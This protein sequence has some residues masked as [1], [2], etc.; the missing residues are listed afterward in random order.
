MS[1]VLLSAL[2]LGCV[3]YALSGGK[4]PVGGGDSGVEATD[5]LDGPTAAIAAEPLV[6]IQAVCSAPTREVLVLESTGEA[7]LVVNSLTLADVTTGELALTLPSP[8]PFSIPAGTTA[9]VVITWTPDD[10]DY[11][12]TLD[13]ALVIASTAHA[14]PTVRVAVAAENRQDDALP[15]I[16]VAGPDCLIIHDGDPVSLIA[17]ITSPVD[18]GSLIVT[19]ES[20]RDGVIQKYTV[21]ADGTST[22][23]AVLSPG[24][25]VLTATVSDPCDRED[26]ASFTL[27]VKAPSATYSGPQPDGLAFDDN[28]TLWIADY[29][30]DRV[31]QVDPL[32][33]GILK[34]L[35]LPG[36]GVDGVTFMDGEMLV[37]FYRTNELVFVDLCDGSETGRWNAPG[38]GVSDVSFDGTDLWMLEYEANRI[39]RLDAGT[40]R[41]LETFA[42]PIDNPNGLAFDGTWFYMTGN[43]D[44][45]HLGR[46]DTS[47]NEVERYNIPGNDPRGVAWDGTDIW[48]SDAS[49]WTIDILVP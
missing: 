13:A 15:E 29:G 20:D 39:H 11:T 22:L 48:Y 5:T 3:D 27:T 40:G 45:P 19:W 7:D 9:D 18:P 25:H 47:F 43:G 21:D 2:G 49:L 1:L 14:D 46:L 17:T 42:A 41:S 12:S 31:Y 38:G 34:A 4:D 6:F 36:D 30:T 35:D 37:S 26:S 16:R 28:G 33:L 24:D 32:T 10:G 23:D 44:D 8:A